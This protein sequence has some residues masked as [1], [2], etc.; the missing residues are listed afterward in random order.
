MKISNTAPY[1]HSRSSLLITY[2]ATVWILLRPLV[3]VLFV[4]FPVE[5]EVWFVRKQYALNEVRSFFS[6]EQTRHI[7]RRFYLYRLLKYVTKFYMDVGQYIVRSPFDTL[8]SLALHPVDFLGMYISGMI[9]SL[10]LFQNL[11]RTDRGL[12][13][14]DPVSL[15]CFESFAAADCDTGFLCGLLLLNSSV[16]CLCVKPSRQQNSTI[17][18]HSSR[19]SDICNYLQEEMGL[20]TLIFKPNVLCIELCLCSSITAIWHSLIHYYRVHDDR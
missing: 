7:F 9:T 20:I 1:H 14:T 6:T 18:V 17:S 16:T 13:A 12:S 10:V 5:V 11:G 15:H 2:E 4:D 8:K 19:H 3:S